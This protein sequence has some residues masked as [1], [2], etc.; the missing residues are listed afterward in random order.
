MAQP[1]NFKEGL[2][3]DTDLDLSPNTKHTIENNTDNDYA[4]IMIF[5][6]NQIT[7]QLMQLTPKSKEYILTPMQ[8]GYQ[9]LVVTNGEITI[10]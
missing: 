1:K 10:N 8:F 4:F 3:K 6:S 2:Y 7:Q 9:M 5:D